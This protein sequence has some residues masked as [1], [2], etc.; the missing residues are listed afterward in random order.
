MATINL[1]RRPMNAIKNA[2][3]II[4]V[5]AVALV[6]LLAAGPIP[7]AL[8]NPP[9]IQVVQYD[10]TFQS[11]YWTGQCGFPVNRH[12]V[13]T[14]RISQYFDQGGNRVREIDAF[15]ETG[16]IS[17]HGI[18]LTGRSHG[19][20]V[21]TWHPDGSVTVLYTGIN[22]LASGLVVIPGNGIIHGTAGSTFIEIDA[23]G[24]VTQVRESGLNIVNPAAVCA[25]L[26]P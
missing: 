26:T 17:A 10:E 23:G 20:V 15:N 8:A 14:L 3:R 18:S 11:P 4:S 1:R 5:L 25:A 22:G 19:P 21:D 12:N 6:A 9:D 2:V 24:N 16:T 13:G 7:K